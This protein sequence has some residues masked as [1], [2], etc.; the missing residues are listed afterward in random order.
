MNGCTILVANQESLSSHEEMVQDLLSIAHTF[1]C[2]LHGLRRYEK[3][4]KDELGGG[5]W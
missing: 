3:A 4:L 2:R 5:G 1:F